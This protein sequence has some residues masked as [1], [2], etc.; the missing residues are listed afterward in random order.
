VLLSKRAGINLL[1]VP[2][3]G[4]AEMT[5]AMITGETKVMISSATEPLNAQV[6]AGKLRILAVASD[7]RSPLTPDVPLASETVPGFV[8]AGW[9]GFIAAANTPA[10]DVQALANAVRMALAEPG[11]KEKYANLYLEPRFMG[12]QEFA[13][14][15]VSVNE[16]YKRLVADLQITPQ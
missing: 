14:N 4:N 15:I 16:F 6:K 5:T 2:Y 11:V 13:A 8:I 3:K 10:A 7:Q 1:P 9:Y 12:P